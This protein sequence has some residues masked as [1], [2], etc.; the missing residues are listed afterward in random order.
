MS[1][2]ALRFGS[3]LTHGKQEGI[4]TDDSSLFHGLRGNKGFPNLE[5]STTS[6]FTS[7]FAKL[8]VG[9]LAVWL[10]A[11]LNI[12]PGVI[13]HVGPQSEATK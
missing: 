8:T 5:H 6:V 13:E 2:L 12:T 4:F 11:C 1:L 9:D 3:T 7:S 10:V